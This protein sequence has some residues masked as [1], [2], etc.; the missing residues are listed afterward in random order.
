[1]TSNLVEVMCTVIGGER[2]RAL[3]KWTGYGG[4]QRRK[5]L[6]LFDLQSGNRCID[7]PRLSGS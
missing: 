7:P 2:L 3:M 6:K 1:M 5:I 4:C